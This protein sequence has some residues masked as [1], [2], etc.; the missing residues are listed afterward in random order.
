MS[1]EQ[2][3]YQQLK[4]FALSQGVCLF[5]VADVTPIQD[6]F[7]IEPQESIAHLKWGIS[8]AVRLSD[9]VLEGIEDR[10][11]LL[12]KHHYREANEL[13]DAVA[14]RIASLI[15]EMGYRAMAI[16]AS[17]TIDWRRQV[18]H[19]SHKK[20]AVLAGLGWLG[21]HNLVV[22][23]SH[24]A[25]IR[26]VTVLTDLPLEVDQPVQEDCGKCR[27]C[28]PVC[29]AGAIHD[30]REEFEHQSCFE[31]LQYFAKKENIGYYICGVCQ[32]ACRE[33]RGK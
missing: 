5:G 8:M 25:R 16:A 28:I 21:R 18:G 31:Q 32:K 22:N 14:F 12:Y 4:T 15:Q 6:S 3:N 10:P 17:Q 24:G 2:D 20:V 27:D 29:P 11:T 26:L 7:H 23:P 33:G 1:E 19:L 9:A 13:L 30:R